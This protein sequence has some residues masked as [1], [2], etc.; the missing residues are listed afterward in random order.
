MEEHSIPVYSPLNGSLLETAVY[1]AA[2]TLV[3]K[4]QF[5][6]EDPV[7]HYYFGMNF[8]DRINLFPELFYQSGWQ[9]MAMSDTG[10]GPSYYLKCN[11]SL[12]YAKMEFW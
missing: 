8:Y 12:F 1:N 3:Q 6:Y 4:T 11:N 7:Y 5:T 2:K 10:E 9:C